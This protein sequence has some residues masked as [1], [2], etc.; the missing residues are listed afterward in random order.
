VDVAGTRALLSLR[1]T[2]LVATAG[3]PVNLPSGQRDVRDS[4]D[5]PLAVPWFSGSFLAN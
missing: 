2:L 5:G 4:Q 1:F 3:S